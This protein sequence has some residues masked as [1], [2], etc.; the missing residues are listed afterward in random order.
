MKIL[1]IE[2]SPQLA[3]FLKEGLESDAIV[4]DIAH[5][6]EEGVR[7]ALL[8]VYDIILLDLGLPK[9]DGL[10][11]ANKIR[12]KKKDLP[13]VVLSGETDIDIKVNL[14]S[15]CDDYVV[16]PFSLKEL[17]ARLRMVRKRGRIMYPNILEVGDLRLDP[18]AHKVTR[19]GREITL[20]NKE[21]A[22]LKYLME[23]K[24][25][26]VS[27]SMILDNVWDMNIDPLTN[28]VDVHIRNLRQRIDRTFPKKLITSIHKRG[29][30]IDG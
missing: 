20:R 21:F 30:K 25:M 19:A 29:Y 9:T 1:V 26:V 3:A 24:G 28:T 8:M 10:T 16:K 22:L 6:G 17:I 5:D 27:R 23:H 14:L 11:V 4:V 13:I 2:D 18:Y 7:L 12:D 15:V